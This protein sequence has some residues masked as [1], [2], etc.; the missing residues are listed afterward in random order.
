MSILPDITSLPDKE[1]LDRFR[2]TKDNSLV[3]LIYKRYVHLIFGVCMKYLKNEEN[4]RDAVMQIF[5]KLL[6]DLA[7]HEIDNF[8]GWLYTIAKNHCL[9]MLRSSHLHVIHQADLKKDLSE[10]MESEL[11]LHQDNSMERERQLLLLEEGIGSL[12]REQ[13]RCIELFY[14]N[15]KSY[16]EV[17]ELTGYNMNQVKSYIQN[18]KRN[19]KIYLE[20]KYERQ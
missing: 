4:S 9:M 20:E 13:K 3:G 11:F 5:E 15:D 2:K 19:L 10:I 1:I 17:A 7:K 12:N 6:S 8:K 16:Q 14:L 18:G